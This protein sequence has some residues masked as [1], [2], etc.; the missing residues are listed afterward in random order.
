[1]HI[2][3]HYTMKIKSFYNLKIKSI[4]Y[5]HKIYNHAFISYNIN[6]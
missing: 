3:F 6:K 4:E 2:N 1:M 5:H